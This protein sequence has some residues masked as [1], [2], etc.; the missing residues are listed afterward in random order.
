MATNRKSPLVAADTNVLM[1]LAGEDEAAWE[2]LDTLKAR[3]T[4]PRLIV[5]PT[6]IEE[7]VHFVN[8]GD[9]QEKRDYAAKALRSLKQWGFA[10]LNLLPVGHGIVERIG[11]EL[12]RLGLIPEEE[13]HDSFIVAE[14][15]LC[16]ADILVSADAH[17]HGIDHQRLH[18]LL[19]SFD[20]KP[21]IIT[22]PRR[23]VRL[24]GGK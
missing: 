17:L 16:G 3:R 11:D 6:V 12:R 1:A 23:V 2:C 10:P 7:L 15:A 14:A 4:T 5:T 19:A 24:L 8:G 18:V 13:R 21:I 9:T 20:V 22:W